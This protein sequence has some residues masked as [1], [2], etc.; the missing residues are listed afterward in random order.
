MASSTAEDAVKGTKRPCSA[1]LQF[2]SIKFQREVIRKENS[3]NRS[4]TSQLDEG[5]I[6]CEE[7]AVPAVCG[8]RAVWVVPCNRRKRVASKLLDAAR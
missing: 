3:A 1:S 2:G 5:A 8:I 6:L 7:E 4:K